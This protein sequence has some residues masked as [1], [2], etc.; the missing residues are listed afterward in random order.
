MKF[1]NDMAW[2]KIEKVDGKVKVKTTPG[3]KK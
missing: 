1:N 3:T 2:L